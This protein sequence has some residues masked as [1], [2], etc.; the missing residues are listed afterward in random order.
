MFTQWFIITI[1]I[2]FILYMGVRT[3]FFKTV[4]KRQER[5]NASMKLT[6]QEAEILIQKHQLQLQRAL[7][8][9]DILTQEMSSLK[10]ELKALKQRNSEY[11]GE[12]DKYKNHIKELEQKI[13][14]LL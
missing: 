5:T 14:A 13:E 4:A 12:S 1:A 9:I 10:I 2:V 6:L 7:G 11:K 8:N 3:F